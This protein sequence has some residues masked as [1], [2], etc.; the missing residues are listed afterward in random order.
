M[1]HEERIWSRD[2]PHSWEAIDPVRAQYTPD[3]TPLILAA[4]KN[5]YEILKILLDRGSA[6]PSPHDVKCNCEQCWI[7]SKQDSLRF[8]MSRLNAYKA[9]SSP[10][11]IALTSKDPILTAFKLSNQLRSL[12]KIESQFCKEYQVLREQVQGKR[13]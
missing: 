9:L 1:E 7:S 11:L 13:F 12:S 10:S 4:H 3:I 6:L 2:T 5:N 8:S